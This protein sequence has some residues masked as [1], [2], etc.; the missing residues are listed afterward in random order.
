MRRSGN[1]VRILPALVG[2]VAGILVIS[3]AGV[4][5]WYSRILPAR[6]PRPVSLS[7]HALPERVLGLDRSDVEL[8]KQPAS[9]G[10]SKQ[11]AW[12]EEQD[13]AIQPSLRAS[14][15]GLGTQA[16]Y[17]MMEGQAVTVTAVNGVISPQVATTAQSIEYIKAISVGAWLPVP[18]SATT[19]CTYMGVNSVF[20]AAGQTGEQ[21]V[22]QV[23]DAPST[24]GQIKCVRSSGERNFSVSIQNQV[25]GE[26][27]ND[28]TVRQL[29]TTT[30]AEVDR[31]WVGL[32]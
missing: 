14:Y 22:T 17:G 30:A 21:L 26:G 2:F 6:N 23:L 7:M 13:S 9:D 10:V 8:R 27:A 29:A 11:L 28:Q 19:I 3:V 12:L 24:G 31:I 4:G 16:W 1:G 20:L 32:D 18:G 15:G 25:G 5:L